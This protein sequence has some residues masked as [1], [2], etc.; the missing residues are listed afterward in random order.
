[1]RVGVVGAGITGLALTHFL[2]RRE[3]D[4]VTFE[5]DTEPGGVVRSGRVD[6]RVVEYGPQRVRLVPAITALVDDIGLDDELIVAEPGLPLYVY[7]DGAL[8]EVPQSLSA[9]ARTDLL[10][11]REKLRIFA[12]PLTAPARPDERAACMFARK[13]GDE[14][15]RNIIEPIF[16]GIY[17]SDPATMPVEH[18]LDPLIELEA[19]HG[20]LLRVALGRLVASD[21]VPPPATF[22]DGLQTL[23][24]ALYEANRSCVH[25]G[26]AV[27]AVR[28]AV[29]SDGYVIDAGGRSADV[30]EVVVTVPAAAAASLLEGLAGTTASP[31]EEL[32][33]NSLA[34]VH[35]QADTAAE[36]FGYQVRRDEPLETLGVTWNDSLFNRDGVYTAFFGGMSGAGALDRSDGDL[37]EVA[38]REFHEVMD[39]DATALDVTRLPDVLP[40]YDTS[41][42]ALD[43]VELPDGVTLATNYTA[44]VGIPGRIREAERVAERLASGGQG[45]GNTTR[46]E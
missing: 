33:Y 40:A 43:D 28:Q 42:A 45:R 31:L 8:R 3:V 15:Y 21:D 11:W 7:A 30:D 32:S 20:S 9:L 24:E 44:R 36:G 17:G 23:P 22:E 4:V 5:A 38:R 10:S 26:V 12:E 19:E 18:S 2:S 35:L 41:W 34:L 16:G 37:G 1:M 46:P 25:L 29:D 6:G 39:V 13:F 27:D 14:T